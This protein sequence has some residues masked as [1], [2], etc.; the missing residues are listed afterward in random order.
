MYSQPDRECA[1][2]QR[3]EQGLRA[4]H[5]H[6]RQ[7]LGAR[8]DRQSGGSKRVLASRAHTQLATGQQCIRHHQQQHHQ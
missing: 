3:A 8:V 2:R 1:I 6:M 5:V 4:Q 7:L